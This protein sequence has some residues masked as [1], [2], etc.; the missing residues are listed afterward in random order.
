MFQLTREEWL[1]I[2]SQNAT[3]T[4]RGQ[5]T[6][7]APYAFTEHG[8]IMV[9]ALLKTDIADKASVMIV[10][11][12]VA[13]RR[14]LASNNQVFQR[15]NQIEYR[16]L[17]SDQ[18]FEDLYSKLE[19][20][21]LD[22]KPKVFFDGQIFDA[23]ECICDL[24]KSAL[25]RV[26]LIDNYIDDSVLTILDK[27]RDGVEATAYTRQISKQLSLDLKK[28]NAQYPEIYVKAFSKAHDRFLIIDDKVYL[29][30]ASLK[31]LGNKWFGISPMPETNAEEL[32]SRLAYLPT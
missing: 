10:K 23:Y 13:M 27:R 20:K 7:Y 21:S 1:S 17:I 26:I 32:L 6:K 9:A 31:D 16:L 22:A 25:R 12:F 19:E 4:S 3:I 18:K 28:H 29:V 11:A 2:R 8:V 24:I 14:F 30:G 5:H 15:L